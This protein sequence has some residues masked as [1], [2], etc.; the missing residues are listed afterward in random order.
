M[1]SDESIQLKATQAC[2]KMLSR[3]RNPPI[4]HMIRLG[5]VPRCVDFLT[6]HNKYVLIKIMF[7]FSILLL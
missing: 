1:S 7:L 2:R 3:E 4:D 6:R 5:V